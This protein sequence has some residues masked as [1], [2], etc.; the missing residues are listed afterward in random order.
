MRVYLNC[1]NGQVC[2]EKKETQILNQD[3]FFGKLISE[4]RIK[5]T[6]L[7]RKNFPSPHSEL[8]LGMVIGINDI[9]KVPS[10]EKALKESGT[11]HVVVVSGFNISLVFGLVIGMLGSRYKL[12]NLIIA[13]ASTLFY[14]F[15]SGF[16][17]PVVRAWVMGSIAAWAK[18]Y[19]RS[20]D[21]FR[22]LMFSGLLMVLIDP[23][24]LFSLSFQL[25][26]LATLGLILYGEFFSKTLSKVSK[27]VLFED[28]GATLSAQVTVWPLISFHFGTVSL[29]SP[30]VN[31]L[32]L[33]TVPISTILGTLF[34]LLGTLSR[35]LGKIIAI[36]MYPFLDVFVRLNVF[37][38]QF[39]FSS[40]GIQVDLIKMSVYYLFVALWAISLARRREKKYEN[41]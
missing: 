41:K 7:A 35:F 34:I 31:M 32:S 13:Q 12:K 20:V 14:A 18:Y 27:S 24:F 3:K 22:L 28:L 8:L 11:I 10:F 2:N 21:G 38:S 15:L 26:F 29:V 36:L 33:W 39:L 40:R 1:F 30:L 16:E 4:I 5:S 23:Y 17:P 19:G 6:K 25:S 37:F 9:D